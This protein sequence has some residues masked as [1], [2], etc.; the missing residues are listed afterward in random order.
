MD[1]YRCENPDCGYV[2]EA[3][4]V[5]TT[6]RSN[7]AAQGY[8]ASAD[9]VF[10]CGDCAEYQG[11]NLALW[12][13]AVEMGKV[14]GAVAA[15]DDSVRYKAE[16]PA[17]HMEALETALYCVG[18]NGSDPTQ[19]YKTMEIKDTVRRR[20]E[21]YYFLHNQLVGAA[22]LGDTSKLAWVTQAVAE[23]RPFGEMF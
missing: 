8:A 3:F 17:L 21:K 18:D 5:K 6:D 2:A 14:A 13:Q 19:K 4:G 22:L 7:I 16:M 23:Q 10:A 15:G 1:Y 11:V 20:M 9:K 12:S